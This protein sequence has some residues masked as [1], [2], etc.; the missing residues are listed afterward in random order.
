MELCIFCKEKEGVFSYN[1]FCGTKCYDKWRYHNNPKRK[2]T[3]L[4]QQK[5]RQESQKGKEAR[6]KYYEKNKEKLL[7]R[8]EEWRAKNK[9]KYLLNQKKYKKAHPLQTAMSNRALYSNQKAKRLGIQGKLTQNELIEL[10]ERLKWKCAY[11]NKQ[12]D[13][14]TVTVDHKTPFSRGGL[15]IIANVAP[16]CE[17]CNKSKATKTAEEFLGLFYFE[18]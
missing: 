5:E 7:K 8:N 11:C 10:F 1:R 14:K 18:E 2:E 12:L 16:C 17:A 3:V 15:N 6:K 4:K 13:F 9:E